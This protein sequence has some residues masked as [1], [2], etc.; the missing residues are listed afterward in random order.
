MPKEG[1]EFTAAA[2]MTETRRV[3][4]AEDS[5]EEGFGQHFTP[6]IR[7]ENYTL[8]KVQDGQWMRRPGRMQQCLWL[9]RDS[10]LRE[11]GK[12]IHFLPDGF[13]KIM[14]RTESGARIG[15]SAEAPS[16]SPAW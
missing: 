16:G 2:H 6:L 13:Y 8:L 15:L 12:E 4:P 9:F 7:V 10:I 1:Q 11:V 14:D 3:G 5:Q